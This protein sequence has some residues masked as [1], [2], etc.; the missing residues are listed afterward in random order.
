MSSIF[1]KVQPNKH[2]VVIPVG[3][4]L[5][6]NPGTTLT[7]GNVSKFTTTKLGSVS[8]NT[9]S[10]IHVNLPRRTKSKGGTK[11]KTS[12]KRKSKRKRFI[13]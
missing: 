9:D 8:I 2:S 3:S 1:D 11:R 5:I 6:V 4:S 13:V 12:S 10:K 7:M